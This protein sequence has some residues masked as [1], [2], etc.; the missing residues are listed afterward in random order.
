MKAKR[1]QTSLKKLKKQFPARAHH[2]EMFEAIQK[3]V[4]SVSFSS[5]PVLDRKELEQGLR[6]DRTVLDICEQRLDNGAF[7]KALTGL[8]RFLAA[9]SGEGGFESDAAGRFPAIKEER[10]PDTLMNNYLSAAEDALAGHAAELGL[11]AAELVSCCQ[12]AA[13]PQLV[14]LREANPPGDD[15]EWK[16][17]HCPCCG[18][19]PCFAEITAEGLHCLR[20]PNCYADYIFSRHYCPRCGHAGLI[21]L[22]MDA[23]PHLLLEKC[24]ECRTY[25]KTWSHG[26]AEPPCP[27]PYLDIVTGEVDEAANL[28]ELRRLSLGVMGV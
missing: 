9:H 23:W 15:M 17:G 6:S 21:T 22:A 13:R 28:Q 26:S 7:L 19:L 3:I 14:T 1:I 20:C 27:Y 16:L 12:Q 11:S 8:F 10:L 5:P 25:L 18:A 2:L 4:Y 24:P